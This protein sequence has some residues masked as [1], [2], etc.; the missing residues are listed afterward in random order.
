MYKRVPEIGGK[1]HH[2]WSNSWSEVRIDEI[3]RDTFMRVKNIT[4]G[5]FYE[6]DPKYLMKIDGLEIYAKQL[7]NSGLVENFPFKP[8]EGFGKEGQSSNVDECPNAED[9]SG[10]NRKEL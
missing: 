4:V 10:T 5:N 8:S 7:T 2:Y 9:P 6:V 3:L 1:Y